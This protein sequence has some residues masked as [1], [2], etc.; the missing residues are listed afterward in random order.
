ML[1]LDQE[2]VVK[3]NYN[4]VDQL[5]LK[6]LGLEYGGGNG[7]YA[8]KAKVVQAIYTFMYLSNHLGRESTCDKIATN[9]Y[10]MADEFANDEIARGS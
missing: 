10:A 9:I 2:S 3:R 4:W 5:D 7:I 1:K 6:Q 8:M